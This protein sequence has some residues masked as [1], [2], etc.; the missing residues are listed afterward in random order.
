VKELWEE[1]LREKFQKIYV[2]FVEWNMGVC[3]LIRVD[4]MCVFYAFP[5]PQRTQMW[6]KVEE[7]GKGRNRGTL[8]NS[9]HFEG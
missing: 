3:V 9:Q 1:V 6:V 8:P 7:S 4:T 2:K 5:T